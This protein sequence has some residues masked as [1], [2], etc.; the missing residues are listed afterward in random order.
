MHWITCWIWEPN[1]QKGGWGSLEAA[2]GWSGV[3]GVG[4]SLTSGHFTF[5]LPKQRAPA[6]RT[7]A[8]QKTLPDPALRRCV[9]GASLL[10]RRGAT[11]SGEQ[12]PAWPQ[13]ERVPARP[14]LAPLLGPVT[15]LPAVGRDGHRGVQPAHLS[16]AEEGR[17]HECLQRQAVPH[18]LLLRLLPVPQERI[19]SLRVPAAEGGEDLG[20]LPE[21]FIDH[22]GLQ[23]LHLGP[24]TGMSVRPELGHPGPGPA[25]PAV[26]PQPEDQGPEP[27]PVERR[28]EPPHI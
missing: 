14:A 1:T 16:E 21:Y 10:P 11:S 26:R 22:R 19:Q 7:H 6:P 15:P 9:P 27:A 8:G 13:P 24:R 3:A 18:G 28:Q 23:V 20:E 2:G 4:E 12:E 17:Q 5:L 25:V